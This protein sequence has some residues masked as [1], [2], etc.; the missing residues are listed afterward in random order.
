MLNMPV[1]EGCELRLA[2]ITVSKS[3]AITTLV[4]KM[5][6]ENVGAVVVVEEGMPIGIITEKDVL[7]KVIKPKKDM[8]LTRAGDVMSQP[9]ISLEFDHTMEEALNLIRKH[10]IRRLVVTKES[11]FFGLVTERRFLETAFLPLPS[12]TVSLESSVIRDNLTHP[13]NGE[14]NRKLAAF[15]R[16]PK[17]YV[18]LRR[19][20]VRGDIFKV[21]VDLKTSGVL[22]FEDG[23]YIT[24]QPALKILDAL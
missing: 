19:A 13:K 20:G 6:V 8:E 2:P 14:N 18:E 11:A 5:I 16:E 7:A 24:T 21:L 22:S 23:K 9:L 17:A 10:D 12:P 4:K 3:D 1:G 15:C